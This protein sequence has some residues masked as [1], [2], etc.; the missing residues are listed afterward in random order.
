MDSKYDLNNDRAPVL[1]FV[2]ENNSGSGTPLA[3]GFK[4]IRECNS[5]NWNSLVMIDKH[6]PSKIAIDNNLR[7]AILCWYSLALAFKIIGRN[8]TEY[9]AKEL[10]KLNRTIEVN[11]SGVQT[12]VNFVEC[13]Y[14]VKLKRENI[15]ENTGKLQF[16]AGLA[17]L[18]DMKSIEEVSITGVFVFNCL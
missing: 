2:A 4:R 1:V 15:T 10:E 5:S 16:E 18:F 17:I 7:G 9:D 14:G 8:R 6:R 3:F 13:L 11:Y 12:V